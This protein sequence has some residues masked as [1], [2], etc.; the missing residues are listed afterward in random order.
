MKPVAR[1]QDPVLRSGDAAAE[2]QE[3]TCRKKPEK[4]TTSERW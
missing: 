2:A 1:Q 4:R 3:G